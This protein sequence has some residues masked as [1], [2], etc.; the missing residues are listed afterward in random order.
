[1]KKVNILKIFLISAFSV[2]IVLSTFPAFSQDDLPDIS[3]DDILN[4]DTSGVPLNN[5]AEGSSLPDANKGKVNEDVVVPSPDSELPA[6]APDVYVVQKGDTLWDICERFLG[7]PWYWPKLWSL[8]PQIGNPHLIYPGDEIKFYGGGAESLPSLEIS[9][10]AE[11]VPE[12]VEETAV[13]E[14]KEE[15]PAAAEPPKEEIPSVAAE[16]DNSHTEKKGVLTKTLSFISKNKIDSA[17]RIVNSPREAYMLAP[18]DKVFLNMKNRRGLSKGDK[19]LVIEVIKKVHHPNK[20]FSTVGY[21]IKIKGELT[22]TNITPKTVEA[23]ISDADRPILRN[24]KVVPYKDVYKTVTPHR[25]PKKIE[26]TVVES[27]QERVIMGAGDIVYLDIGSK[28][29]LREGDELFV[30]RKEDGFNED[31]S[32]PWITVG[33]LLVVQVLPTTST[34]MVIENTHEIEKGDKVRTYE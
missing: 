31:K 17:G 13:E 2:G 16:S 21:Q 28:A 22:V 26:G 14:E 29:G 3:D 33:R 7:N 8:N 23:V 4:E 25:N 27:E 5:N 11:D 6:G 34:A 20:A 12:K 15:L 32:L 19:L 18:G 10:K 24:D 30:V 1:M 9:K